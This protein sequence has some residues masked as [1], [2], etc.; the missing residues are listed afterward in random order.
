ME[1]L[2]QEASSQ[3]NSSANTPNQSPK[4]KEK[5][6]KQED[7]ENLPGKGSFVRENMPKVGMPEFVELVTEVLKKGTDL[8]QQCEKELT[9]QA[10]TGET[11][12]DS[13][14]LVVEKVNKLQVAEGKLTTDLLLQM[15]RS[16]EASHNNS[17]KSSAFTPKECMNTPTMGSARVGQ[18]SAKETTDTEHDNTFSEKRKKKKASKRRD[19]RNNSSEESEIEV[20][21]GKHKIKSGKCANPDSIGLKCSV[22]YPHE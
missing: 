5:K 3:Q 15:L 2:E 19:R 10:S 20:N 11:L 18:S 9:K 22:R 16:K 21:R 7:K 4:K 13:I 6:K 14:N 8:T 17:T 12:M 1:Q